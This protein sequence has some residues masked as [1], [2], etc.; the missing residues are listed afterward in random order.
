MYRLETVATIII[1]LDFVIFLSIAVP[2]SNPPGKFYSTTWVLFTEFDA[3]VAAIGGVVVLSIAIALA[4][5]R[6][7][8]YS[9]TWV[10]FIE[11]DAVSAVVAAI[12]G[13]CS[14]AIAK[15]IAEVSRITQRGNAAIWI[16]LQNELICPCAVPA[17]P[18]AQN[19]VVSVPIAHAISEPWHPSSSAVRG[20]CVCSASPWRHPRT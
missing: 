5:P 18:P 1:A 14:R 17:V 9:T 10:F 11:F 20:R 13:V 3:V 7:K 4:N 15:A 19:R 6:W 16:R 8:F 12:G 2:V